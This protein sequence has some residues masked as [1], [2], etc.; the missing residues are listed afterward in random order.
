MI[1]VNNPGTWSAI[2]WPLGH[3]PWHGWT[4]TDLIFPFFLFM[5]GMSI[6]FSRK[7]SGREALRR[8]AVLF[9]LGV[10][11]AAYPFFDLTTVRIPGVL[12]RIALCYLATWWLRRA[13]GTAGQAATAAALLVGY[14]ALMTLVP[15]PRGLAPNLQ[16]ETN[17]GAWLDRLLLEGHLWKQSKT[18]DPEGLLSTLPAIATTLLGLLAGEWLKGERPPRAKAA[19]LLGAGAAL[20]L[21]G[22]AWGESFPINKNLW[23]S[24]YVLLSG[25]LASCGFGLC[26]LVA[27]VYGWR[28]WTWPFVIYGTNAIVVFV[29]SGLLAKTIG[30]IKVSGVSLQALIYRGAFASWLAPHDASL[31]F[32]LATVTFWFLVLAWM[33]ARGIYIKV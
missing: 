21:A 22:V 28:R 4:P 6:N 19:G 17:L 9:G 1:L 16:P 32:A 20:T 12:Q 15:V 14:W 2:Y 27:D 5:V 30:L 8:S 25:G 11:M 31:G 23:T 29:A 18:W 24:S 7:A 13:L 33:D 26:Y 10:F 3:A